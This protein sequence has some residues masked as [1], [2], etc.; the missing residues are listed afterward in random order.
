M[1]LV[2]VYENCK[3]LMMLQRYYILPRMLESLVGCFTELC[4]CDFYWFF[5]HFE[6]PAFFQVAFQANKN[7]PA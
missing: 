6:F 5:F 2:T 3:L 1:K 4:A 7:P